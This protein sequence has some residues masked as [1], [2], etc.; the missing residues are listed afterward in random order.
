MRKK[1]QVICY[2]IIVTFL[3]LIFFM[4]KGCKALEGNCIKIGGSYKDYEG[5]I[6]YCFSPAKSKKVK[7]PILKD[8]EGKEHV[9]L[10]R[11]QV[12]KLNKKLATVSPSVSA[13]L[14]NR[15]KKVKKRQ[16]R[17]FQKPFALLK[18]FLN[19]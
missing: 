2:L 12:T 5:N 10:S 1:D 9:I 11:E 18:W 3:L 8:K 14:Q 16:P 7:L 6:E 4:G 13:L 19:N 17:N 15:N